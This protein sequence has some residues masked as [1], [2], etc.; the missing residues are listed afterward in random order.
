MPTQ[1]LNDDGT[2]S[3]A[4]MLMSSHHAFRRDAACFAL[5]LADGSRPA[6]VLAEEWAR[7]RGA[8][9]GHHTIEDTAMFPDLRAKH[10]ELGATLDKLDA[11]HRAIDPLLERGDKLFADL[12]T[13]RGA[14]SD[15]I[16]TLQG[17]LKEHLDLEEHAIT[18]HLRAAKE[19]PL[20]PTED[21]AAMYAEGFA[22]S[23][24]GISDAVLGKMREMLPAALVEKL[25]AART[26]F[27]ERCRRV[28]GYAHAGA[29]TTSDPAATART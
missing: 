22:W 28:W 15:L 7:F 6:A 14:A 9:H 25:P 23:M 8:L 1:L 17:L 10:P 2:A 4:T 29:S 26:T 19:F 12:G 3:M 16:A 5:A 13:Q 11:H 27:D 18:P 20:P 21:A 24:A